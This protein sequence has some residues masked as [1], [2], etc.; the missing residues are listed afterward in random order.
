MHEPQVTTH[1]LSTRVPFQ[2]TRTNYY[3]RIKRCPVITAPNSTQL[4]STASRAATAW[5]AKCSFIASHSFNMLN[6]FCH[7]PRPRIHI[8]G[9]TVHGNST[10]W[11]TRLM[12]VQHADDELRERQS[13]TQWCTVTSARQHTLRRSVTIAL[14][15]PRGSNGALF[16]MHHAL[17]PLHSNT[18]INIS[19][20]AIPNNLSASSLLLSRRLS[21]KTKH[22]I[23]PQKTRKIELTETSLKV[24][25]KVHSWRK[26]VGLSLLN[27]LTYLRNLCK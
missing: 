12:C 3:N 16:N 2:S 19:V 10:G 13:L 4:N 27:F 23:T 9:Y 25:K 5:H 26:K 15:L 6:L 7:F 14:Q 8:C 18:C 17:S 1:L 24:P 11:C 20:V 22:A 21:A